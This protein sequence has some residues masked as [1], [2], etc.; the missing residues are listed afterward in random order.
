[1]ISKQHR[2]TAET[3]TKKTT[4]NMFEKFMSVQTFVRVN[5]V[6]SHENQL[7][8]FKVIWTLRQKI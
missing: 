5:I 8:K 6:L 1:M 7:L 2:I 3:S 4:L